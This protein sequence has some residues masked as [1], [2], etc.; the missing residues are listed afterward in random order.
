MGKSIHT[1][2]EKGVEAG[3]QAYYDSFPV[4][5]DLHINEI[6]KLEYLIPKV[7]EMLP[8]GIY[9]MEISD[10][11]FIGFSD[12]LVP[13]GSHDRQDDTFLYDLYDFK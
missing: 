9:E 1:G 2:I 4:I 7:K 11:D 3:V 5:D 6:I 10:S 8:D 13:V 12:L